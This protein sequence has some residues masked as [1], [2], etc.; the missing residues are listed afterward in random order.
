MGRNFL[1]IFIKWGV[2]MR[3]F[4]CTLLKQKKIHSDLFIW[5]SKVYKHLKA[6]FERFWFQSYIEPLALKT[7][8]DIPSYCTSFKKKIEGNSTN[9]KLL[10]N[11]VLFNFI[12]YLFSLH[13]LI[14]CIEMW[15]G[16]VCLLSRHAVSF[17]NI[18]LFHI[19]KDAFTWNALLVIV[20]Q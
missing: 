16:K 19:W 6:S 12:F 14:F 1:N 8:Y 9:V 11:C 2:R 4:V 15:A 5:N 7:F 10:L 18:P 13:L 3:R 17:Y 20:C